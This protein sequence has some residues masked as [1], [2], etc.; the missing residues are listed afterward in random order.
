MKNYFLTLLVPLAAA[1]TN[2]APALP[3]LYPPSRRDL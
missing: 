2:A 3:L 1:C